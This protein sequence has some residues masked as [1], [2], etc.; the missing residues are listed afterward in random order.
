M[1]HAT[2]VIFGTTRFVGNGITLKGLQ[3]I[4]PGGDQFPE[5]MINRFQLVVENWNQFR[6]GN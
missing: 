3:G 6:R 5:E 4:N 1:N 2:V